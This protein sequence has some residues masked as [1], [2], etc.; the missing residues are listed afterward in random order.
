MGLGILGIEVI[1][2]VR[3]RKQC[4]VT[5][6]EIESYRQRLSELTAEGSDKKAEQTITGELQKLAREVGASTRMLWIHPTSSS[7]KT[8]EADT[9]ELIR[10]LI[11]NFAR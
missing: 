2:R 5:H 6:K 1:L 7:L 9:S 4:K 11:E 3:G 10:I 8:S